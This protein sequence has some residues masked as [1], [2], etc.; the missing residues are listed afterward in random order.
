LAVSTGGD[1]IAKVHFVGVCVLRTVS[2]GV[3]K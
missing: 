2:K 3:W 1:S